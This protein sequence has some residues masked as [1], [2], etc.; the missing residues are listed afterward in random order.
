MQSFTHFLMVE[1]RVRENPSV[2]LLTLLGASSSRGL[3]ER[4]G[5][6]GSGFKYGLALLA[7]E[8]LLEH[9]KVCL[10][11]AVF[12]FFREPVSM[13]DSQGRETW[14]NKI[15]MKQQGGATYDLNISEAF[16]AI[17]WTDIGMA[18]REVISNGL[19]GAESYDGTY[20]TFR[21]KTDVP[22]EGRKARAEDKLVRIYLPLTEEVEDYVEQ[23]KSRFICL[24]SNY[25]KTAKVLAKRAAGPAKIFRKGVQVGEFGEESLFD[26]NLSDISLNESR[27][28]AYYEARE[29]SAHAFYEHGS[30]EQRET[31]L[32]R[33]IVGSEDLWER[34]WPMYGLRPDLPGMDGDKIGEAWQASVRAVFGDAVLVTDDVTKEMVRKKGYTPLKVSSEFYSFLR[35]AKMPS[36]SS[37][38]NEH[39][40]HGKEVTAASPQ[41]EKTL[42]DVWETLSRLR[43]TQ[44]KEPPKAACFC[45]NTADGMFGYYKDGT[46]YI[47]SDIKDDPGLMLLQTVLE[48]VS[49]HVT[50]ATDNSRDFQEF[51]FKVAAQLLMERGQ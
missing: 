8:D 36:A 43:M 29:K 6:F 7:R 41:V 30:A 35:G 31:F 3:E 44:G 4:I 17:D 47:R 1:N 10:G 11:P 33:L 13:R 28:V 9:V 34:S 49:H 21:M 16:G 15:K 25:D 48:E 24:R 14:T 46:C 51:A 22:A 42:T 32:R 20:R 19:D 40:M 2:E 38:L 39:E 5:Q 50:G 23:V 27:N 26:Y 45:Q 37:V 12:T 18:V